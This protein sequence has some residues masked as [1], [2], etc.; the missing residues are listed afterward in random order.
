M[1]DRSRIS[2]LLSLILRHRPDEFGLNIDEYGFIPVDEVI[3]VEL[4]VPRNSRMDRSNYEFSHQ[5]GVID[6]N[7]FEEMEEPTPLEEDM[8]ETDESAEAETPTR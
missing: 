2:K 7:L 6:A 4:R 8:E 1:V 3:E 5:N